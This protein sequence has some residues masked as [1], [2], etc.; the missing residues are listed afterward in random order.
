ME[1][2]GKTN[3]GGQKIGRTRQE[4][5]LGELTKKFIQLIKHSENNTIDL[6]FAVNQLNVQ[7]RRIYDITNVLEGIGLIE[8]C[9][10]NK[11]RWK[12]SLTM[13]I[14]TNS[15]EP[16]CTTSH[17]DVEDDH[18]IQRLTEELRRMEEEEKWLDETIFSVEHQLNEISKDSLYE[19]FA[20]VT[21]EDI[22]KLNQTKENMDNTLLAIRAPKG[23]KIEIPDRFGNQENDATADVK[24]EEKELSTKFPNQIYLTSPKEEILVYMIT[25]EN[26][27]IKEEISDGDKSMDSDRDKLLCEE[28]EIDEE[29]QNGNNQTG[30]ENAGERNSTNDIRGLYTLSNMYVN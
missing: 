17:H 22:K 6:N 21:Y 5:S 30:K 8:K 9:S 13:N 24:I 15:Q 2:I 28:G 1:I 11:I 4:N 12:G 27:D 14:S 23:T 10:K 25:N 26:S 7:K 18:E 29:S 19:Q 16:T 3:P 20:Y